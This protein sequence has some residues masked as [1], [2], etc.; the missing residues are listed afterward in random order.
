MSLRKN[1]ITWKAVPFTSARSIIKKKLN[2]FSSRQFTER[3]SNKVW[4]TNFKDLPMWLRRKAVAEFRLTT[5]YDCLLKHLHRNHVAR[6]PFC[7]FCDFPEDMDADH[8]RHFPALKKGS[9]LCDIYWQ[10]GVLLGS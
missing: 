5:G 6:A 7:T 8:I 10:A 3:N 1:E 4:W 9:C 2:V